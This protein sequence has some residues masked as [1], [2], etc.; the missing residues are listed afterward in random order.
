MASWE[1]SVHCEY[2]FKI[3]FFYFSKDGGSRRS[4][5][6]IKTE[7]EWCIVSKGEATTR[8]VN[9][10]RAEAEISK[11]NVYRARMQRKQKIQRIQKSANGTEVTV[12]QG[13]LIFPRCEV[14]CGFSEVLLISIDADEVS[15]GSNAFEEGCRM[16]AEANGGVDD[17]FSRLRSEDTENLFLK[18]RDVGD[19]SIFV[20]ICILSH[21]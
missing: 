16:T 21:F 14:S 19:G 13:D 8:I 18:N 6:L 2:F 20:Y 1:F 9:V 7:V 4:V 10:R 17:R 5:R 3:F 11:E 15:G 12:E